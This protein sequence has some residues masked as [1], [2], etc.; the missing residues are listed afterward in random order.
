MTVEQLER[1]RWKTKKDVAMVPVFAGLKLHDITSSLGG[2]DREP[3][4][5]NAHHSIVK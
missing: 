1:L 2:S 3:V 5:Q 4:G